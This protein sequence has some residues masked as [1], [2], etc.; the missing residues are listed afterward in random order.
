MLPT[1]RAKRCSH[2]Q[3][4]PFATVNGSRHVQKGSRWRESVLGDG[5]RRPGVQVESQH[6]L[7]VDDLA[8]ANEAIVLVE[9]DRGCGA[10]HGAGEQGVRAWI[11]AKHP[12]DCVDHGGAVA[13]PLEPRVDQE[14]PQEVAEGAAPVAR[15]YIEAEH[16]EADRDV[17]DVDRPIPRASLRRSSSLLKRIRNPIRVLLLRRQGPQNLDGS[18]IRIRDLQQ[19][20]ARPVRHR[21]TARSGVVSHDSDESTPRT[22]PTSEHGAAHDG[23]RRPTLEWNPADNHGPRP[24]AT[25]WPQTRPLRAIPTPKSG[26]F[27]SPGQLVGSSNARPS[28][29]GTQA[30]PA[31]Y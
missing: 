21:K 23:E 26:R 28:A 25:V 11:V 13:S 17:I 7:V 16:E 22:K 10:G 30:G 14:L 20:H 18:P 19:P 4:T 29:P 6:D 5:R 1:Y 15:R 31:G 9:A 24:T 12:H 8:G 2:R 27:G 3:G